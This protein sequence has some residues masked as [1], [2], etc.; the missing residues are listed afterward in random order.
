MIQNTFS[1]TFQVMV[2]VLFKFLLYRKKEESITYFSEK[3]WLIG[4]GL[5]LIWKCEEI[6]TLLAA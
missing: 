6:V 1:L 3:R 2:F 5:R 4:L